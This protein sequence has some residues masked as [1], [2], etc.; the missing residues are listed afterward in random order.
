MEQAYKV[1]AF[2]TPELDGWTF[3][4]GLG[5]LL[6]QSDDVVVGLSR[7]LDAEVHDHEQAQFFVHLNEEAVM[8]VAASWSINP[9]EIEPMIDDRPGRIADACLAAF[10]SCN[11]AAPLDSDAQNPDRSV[12]AR[13]AVRPNCGAT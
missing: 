12:Q 9:Q 4:I 13:S 6:L 3:A 2:V 5:I 11:R 10:G 7:D 1:G 8:K